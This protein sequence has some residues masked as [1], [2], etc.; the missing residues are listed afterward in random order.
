M[1]STLATVPWRMRTRAGA[2]SSIGRPGGGAAA[3]DLGGQLAEQGLLV[4]EVPVEEALGHAGGVDD[5]DHPGGG[6]ALLGEERAAA[7]SSCC[8]RS[9]PCVVSWRSFM[10]WAGRPTVTVWR[11]LTRG[12]ITGGWLARPR[13]RRVTARTSSPAASRG[14]RRAAPRRSWSTASPATPGA[15]GLAEA[16]AAAGF[17]VDLPLLP[18]HG[19]SVDDMIA[20]GWDDWSGAAEAA[21]QSLAGRVDKVVVAGLSMGGSLTA[22]LAEPPPRDRGHRAAS[23]RPWTVPGRDGRSPPGDGGRRAST[24]SRPSAATWPTPAAAGEGLRRHPAGPLLSLA[25]GA[26]EFAR[27]TWPRSPARCWS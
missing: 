24:A 26:A 9:A 4:L 23:T 15:R 5:V 7:S 1:N 11:R 14:R 10:V 13:D 21:Y 8:L 18:G 20:T 6:V 3:A 25:A 12:S 17:T 22:W 2:S 16:F 19:T 27:P